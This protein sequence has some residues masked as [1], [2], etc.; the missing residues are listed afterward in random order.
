MSTGKTG[1]FGIM[2]DS[3]CKWNE[4]DSYCHPTLCGIKL[5][6]QQCH[7]EN[8]EHS[9][10]QDLASYIC[11]MNVTCNKCENCGYVTH[12]DEVLGSSLENFRHPDD[13]ILPEPIESYQFGRDLKRK[14]LLERKDHLLKVL[15]ENAQQF[16]EEFG[17][18]INES[19]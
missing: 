8:L 13:M 12:D 11:Y 4:C 18:D 19:T 3:S 2:H 17:E 6:L 7:E 9:G 14:V 1:S 10:N 16:K 5:Y 15:K